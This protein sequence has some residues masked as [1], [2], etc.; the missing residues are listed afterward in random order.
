M[1]F[2]KLTLHHNKQKIWVNYSLIESLGLNDKNVTI[3][4][5]ASNRT[6]TPNCHV[7]ESPEKI[8]SLI[9][10]MEC[11]VAELKRNYLK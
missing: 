4:Y 11:K 3:L 10:E 9:A 7:E 1:T 6:Q 5:S 8:L 2:I